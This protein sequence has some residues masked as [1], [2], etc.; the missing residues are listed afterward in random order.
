[1]APTSQSS[2]IT[3]QMPLINKVYQLSQQISTVGGATTPF[4]M[5]NTT[6]LT[7]GT[8]IAVTFTQFNLGLPNGASS[9]TLL[10]LNSNIQYQTKTFGSTVLM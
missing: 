3:I 4:P 6:L 2:A 7:A 8:V 5:L 1:M 9:D 10:Y